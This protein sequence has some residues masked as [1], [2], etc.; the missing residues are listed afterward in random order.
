MV[1]IFLSISQ[2]ILLCPWILWGFLF[3][4]LN[5]SKSTKKRAIFF[6]SDLTTILLLFSVQRLVFQLFNF[7]LGVL[8]LIGAVVLAIIMVIYEWK[9]KSDLD[10]GKVLKR[11]WRTLF[12]LLTSVYIITLLIFCV[13]WIIELVK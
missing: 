8:V 4:L 5:N 6:A 12:V 11:I 7:D 10:L 3:V 2:I 9:T 13:L 1:D